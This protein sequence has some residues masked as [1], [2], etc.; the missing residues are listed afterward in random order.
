ML[1]QPSCKNVSE[2]ICD[3]IA[4]LLEMSESVGNH[5]TNFL[6]QAFTRYLHPFGKFL[7][8]YSQ[9]LK[10]ARFCHRVVNTVSP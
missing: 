3:P 6:F 8:R 10:S 4:D 1:L 7:R 5:V 2:L 9:L